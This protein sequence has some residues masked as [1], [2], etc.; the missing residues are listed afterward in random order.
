MYVS[1]NRRP[2]SLST[3]R[4]LLG[5]SVLTFA[6]FTGV[7]ADAKLAK[8]GASDV[9]FTAIGPAGM[10]IVGTTSDLNVN[11]DG[12]TITFTVPL[13]N[14]TTGISLRDKHMKEKYLQVPQYPNATLKV[15]RAG[16]HLAKGAAGS[17]DAPGTMSIHG[18]ENPVT[19]HFVVNPSSGALDVTGNTTVNI[20]DYGVDVPSYLGVTVK[21]E[22]GIAVHF[23]G[24][25]S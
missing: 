1:T 2:L 8:S 23:V 19:V 11:D 9:S 4:A 3:G 13:G 21:P 25:D 24:N 15:P 20:K 17:G 22:V 18:K 5:L 10:K 6:M 7:E 16:I 14:L 12:T